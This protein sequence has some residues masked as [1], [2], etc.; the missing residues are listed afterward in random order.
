VGTAAGLADVTTPGGTTYTFTV[1]YADETAVNAATLG[2]ANVQVTGPNAFSTFATAV[3]PPTS[4]GSPLTVTY[5]F[6]APGGAWSFNANGAYTVTRKAGQVADTSGN[7]TTADRVLGTFQARV[8]ITV[9][10]T[11]DTTNPGSLR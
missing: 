9:T 2:N 11:T 5:Q 10:N 4:N 6:T 7:T 8:P 3:N 1:T